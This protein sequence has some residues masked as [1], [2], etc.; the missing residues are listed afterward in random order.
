MAFEN[1]ECILLEES[2]ASNIIFC[3]VAVETSFPNK[4]TST[5]LGCVD[6]SNDT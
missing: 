1:E 3:S 6:V 2:T 5:S 4:K